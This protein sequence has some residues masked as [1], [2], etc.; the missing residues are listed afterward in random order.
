M[1]AT[2]AINLE[3]AGFLLSP[4]GRAG[5]QALQK[6]DLAETQTLLLLNELR[7]TFSASEAGALL[8]LARLRRKAATKFPFADQLFL[9][10]E[11]L[12]QATAWPVAEHHSAWL[13]QH[14]PAGTILDLGCGIGGDTLALAQRR[15]VIAFELD[16]VRL[17][18]AQANAAALGLADQIEFHQ[19]DWVLALEN[20]QLPTVVA[21][22]ADPSRRVAG[23]RVFSLHQM[24]PPLASLLRLQQQITA[25]GVKVMPGLNDAEVPIDCGVEFISH[26]GVCKEAILW[27]GSPAVYKR[28]ASVHTGGAWQL[29]AASGAPPPL[30]TLQAGQFLH[31]PDP[32]LIRAGSF[33]ELCQRLDAFLFNA[34]IAYLVSSQ[35]KLDRL[36]QSFL[37]QEIHPF[38]LKML[39][40]RLQALGI[41]EVELKKRGFPVEPEE[42]RKRLKLAPGGKPAVII[43]TQ[44]E[45]GDHIMLI[46]AR[47]GKPWPSDL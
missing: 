26:A 15:R 12:E 34:Q 43:F 10:A 6:Q 24:Q 46:C 30:G 39:N 41:G 7:R 11:A 21:A 14:A 17:Q 16:P 31:E 32:A 38:S 27:F 40:R 29:M 18:F 20:K 19:A 13:D 44:Q 42:L 4:R 1:D 28:W 9:T 5:L 23:K 33:A 36:V 2:T 22:Y 35:L 47:V 8:A 37:I 3:T 45:N 25:L